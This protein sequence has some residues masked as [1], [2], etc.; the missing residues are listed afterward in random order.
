MD[1]LKTWWPLLVVVLLIAVVVRRI[2]GEPLDLKDAIALPVVLLVVGGRAIAD[3]Q[4]TIIDMVW[5]T[6]LSL[7]SLCFGAARSTTTVIERRGDVFVQRYRWMTFVLLI[8]SL[9]VGAALGLLAQ[10]LGMHEEARP[11]TFTIGL[12]LAGEGGITL[13]RAA[14]RGAPMPW[15]R[16]AA[17]PKTSDPDSDPAPTTRNSY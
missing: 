7:V 2:R 17:S 13:I 15:S 8:V 1:L 12:G 4:L 14:R 5:L 10:H 9:V 16:T 11:L 6:L 3:V